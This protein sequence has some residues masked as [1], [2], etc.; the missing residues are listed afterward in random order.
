MNNFALTAI[1]LKV[2]VMK[3]PTGGVALKTVLV[4]REGLGLSHSS[5]HE[6]E[7]TIKAVVRWIQEFPLPQKHGAAG[8]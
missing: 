2:R 4:K 7:S 6:S 5:V 8:S 3:E 1:L